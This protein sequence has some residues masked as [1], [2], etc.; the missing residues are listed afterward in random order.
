[1]AENQFQS[2]NQRKTKDFRNIKIKIVNSSK[3]PEENQA[4]FIAVDFLNKLN[5]LNEQLE[6][7]SKICNKEKKH[8]S[9]WNKWADKLE[10]FCLVFFLFVNALITMIFLVVGYSRM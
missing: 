4:E 2:E 5:Q 8:E 3:D 7:F 10:A 6:K 1:M 9:E